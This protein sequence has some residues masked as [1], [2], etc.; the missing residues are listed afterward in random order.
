MNEVDIWEIQVHGNSKQRDPYNVGEMNY[1]HAGRDEPG[2]MLPGP[3]VDKEQQQHL[4]DL[5]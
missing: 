3:R 5:F 2:F 1:D 4:D